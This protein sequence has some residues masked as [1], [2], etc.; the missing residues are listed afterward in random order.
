MYCIVCVGCCSFLP[1]VRLCAAAPSQ[2]VLSEVGVVGRGDE[3]VG[4]WVIHVLVNPCMVRV[5]HTVLLRQ[6]VH[7]KAIGGHELVLLGCTRQKHQH[8]S[9]KEGNYFIVSKLVVIV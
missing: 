3:V 9:I 2:L 7:G 8:T 1:N 6:H 4:Q 5:K